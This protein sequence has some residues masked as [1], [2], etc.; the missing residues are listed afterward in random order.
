MEYYT[1]ISG[2]KFLWTSLSWSKAHMA[3]QEVS[4]TPEPEY[5]LY[6]NLFQELAVV[7]ARSWEGTSTVVNRSLVTDVTKAEICLKLYRHMKLAI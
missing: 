5:F 2:V 6:T 1:K 3:V 4:V 7:W